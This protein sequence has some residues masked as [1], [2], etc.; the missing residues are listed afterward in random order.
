MMRQSIVSLSVVLIVGALQAPTTVVDGAFIA[1]QHL[2]APPSLASSFGSSS[3]SASS[4]T[5]LFGFQRKRRKNG[6]NVSFKS[7]SRLT[8]NNKRRVA[9]AGRKG[10]KRFVDPTKVFVG[11]I[12]HD[13]TEE[14]VSEF[15]AEHMGHTKYVISI[16]IIRDWK[17][18]K[19]K[20]YGFVVFSD[21]MFATCAMEFCNNKKLMGRALSLNQGKKKMDENT[22]FI[23]KK[24]KKGNDDQP[25]ADAEEAAISEGLVEAAGGSDD[26]DDDE[27]TGEDIEDGNDENTAFDL[28]DF[29]GFDDAMLFTDNDSYEGVDD[30]G[31]DGVFEEIY[32]EKFEPLSED[33]MQLNREA[34]RDIAKRKKRRKLPHKGFERPI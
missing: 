21:P 4:P 30:D 10:T 20:G 22:L 3:S 24:N 7:D 12:P 18:G 16:K 27:E 33:E 26:D 25:P 32:P 9:T 31:F 14:N 6:S 29:D 5:A 2:S 13:A 23:K 8:T 19:S 1:Q 34:R 28:A 11:N 15:L 17:T